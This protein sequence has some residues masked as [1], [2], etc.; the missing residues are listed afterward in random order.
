MSHTN[1]QSGLYTTGEIAKLCGVSVRIVQYYDDRGIL[2][3]SELSEGGRRL[4][5]ENDLK[6]MHIICFLKET[7]LPLNGISA[8]LSEENPE[9][10]IS[11]LL[12]QQEKDLREELSECQR[13]LELIDGIR[14]EMKEL[15]RF[16]VESIG[17]IAHVMK[18]KKKL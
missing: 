7:G 16:S 8:L 9:S 12:E 6:R 1:G 2:T 11:V 15:D 4:Y 3:P 14:R 18:Q 5:T 10:I 17:D 13:R